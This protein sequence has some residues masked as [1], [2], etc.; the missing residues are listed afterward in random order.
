MEGDREQAKIAHNNLPANASLG[1]GLVSRAI[2]PFYHPDHNPEF[3]KMW[4]HEFELVTRSPFQTIHS[5]ID[6][7]LLDGGEF[8]TDG[9]FLT[10]WDR[11]RVIALDDCNPAKSVKTIYAK[12]CLERAGWK[13]LAGDNNDRNG[14]SIFARP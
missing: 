4:N 8:T 3:R 2:K 14:W 7:L 6:L 10:L 11:C 1:I 5:K 9:D 13:L 12:T